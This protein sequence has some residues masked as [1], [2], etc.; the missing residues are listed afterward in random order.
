MDLKS[1]SAPLIL[2][3]LYISC[4]PTFIVMHLQHSPSVPTVCLSGISDG[5]YK[6]SGDQNL[7]DKLRLYPVSA[8][9][10]LWKSWGCCRMQDLW[11]LQKSGTR[12]Q[13][14]ETLKL[15]NKEQGLV[16]KVIGFVLIRRFILCAC[17][18][19]FNWSSFRCWQ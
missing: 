13:T 9:I 14:T 8:E 18:Y 2:S 3:S 10:P 19:S 15:K 11:V 12:Q 17:I 5:I 16:E 6:M 7:G 1:G 4:I